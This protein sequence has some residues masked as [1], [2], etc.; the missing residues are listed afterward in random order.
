MTNSTV[1]NLYNGDMRLDNLENQL[2]NAIY[3][4]CGGRDVPM[5]AVIGVL[6]R[7]KWNLMKELDS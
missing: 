4:L 7:V 5:L 2:E 6:E 1:E 3:E